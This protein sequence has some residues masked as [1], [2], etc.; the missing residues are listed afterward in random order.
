MI[1]YDGTDFFDIF[2]AKSMPHGVVDALE[3]IDVDEHDAILDHPIFKI[4]WHEFFKCIFVWKTCHFV[5]V[6][7]MSDLIFHA[8]DGIDICKWTD[9][10]R[11]CTADI[12]CYDTFD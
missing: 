7:S 2:V 3:M 1:F 11:G 4:F 10:A 5:M 6:C 12:P 9:H 8:Y